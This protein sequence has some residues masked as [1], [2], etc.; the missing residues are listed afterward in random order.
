ML[1]AC[2]HGEVVRLEDIVKAQPLGNLDH[3]IQEIHDILRSYYELALNRFVDN[4]R[5]Q[6]CDFF[7]VT[8]PETP[9]SLFSPSFVSALSISQLEQLA[10]ED[11]SIR[12]QR[13]RL[14]KEIIQLRD[15]KQILL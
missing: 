9:L 15:G 8:G 13:A 2:K 11:A 14:D 10:I 7:L 4:V 5:M 6:V 1:D 3:E 12:T